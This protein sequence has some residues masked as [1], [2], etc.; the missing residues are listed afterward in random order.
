MMKI[1]LKGDKSSIGKKEALEQ[2]KSM[3][4]VGICDDK[5]VSYLEEPLLLDYKRPH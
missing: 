1:I 3:L 2:M 5:I 4:S